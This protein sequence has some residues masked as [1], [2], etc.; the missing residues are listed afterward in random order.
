VCS[1]SKRNE[2]DRH[3]SGYSAVVSGKL[4]ECLLCV[5]TPLHTA[6]SDV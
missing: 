6:C 4:Y 1:H 3:P 2:V 5:Y